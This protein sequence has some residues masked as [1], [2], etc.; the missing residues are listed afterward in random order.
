M[1]GS[2]TRSTSSTRREF[3]KRTGAAAAGAAV[4]PALLR[5]PAEALG[6]RRPNIIVIMSDEHNAGVT[7]CYGNS[8]VRTPNLDG[9][10]R[11][12]VTFEGC[13]TNSP[14]CVPSRL[15]FT[16]GKYAS[17]V[18]AWSNDC[19]LPSDDCP[20]LPRIMNAAGYESLLCGKMHYDAARRYG[21]TEV[22]RIGNKS[23]KSGKGARRKA[24]DL[25]PKPGISGRFEHFHPG[26]DSSVLNHDRK[27]TPGVLEFLEG[28][29]RDAKPFFLLAGYVA[30]HFPL[31]V[32]ERYWEPY[33]GKVPMPEIPAGHLDALPL[34]Y[35]HLRIGFNV[36][37]AP[38]D[39][40]RKGRELYYGLTEWFDDEVGKVLEALGRSEFAED[41]VVIY[42]SDHGENIGEHG[43]WWKNCM[44]EHAA[45]VPLVVSW[46]ARWTG[47]ARRTQ[48]CSLV[49]VVKTIAELGGASVPDDWDGDSMLPWL[50]DDGF[51]WKDTALSEYYAHN[52][53]SG[54]AMLRRGSMKYVYHT[55]A[56]DRRPPERE[57][58]DL[59]ADPG[60]FTNLAGVAGHE[61]IV[62]EMHAA[63]VGEIGEEPDLTEQRCRADYA[64]GYGR[65][66]NRDDKKGSKK[67]KRQ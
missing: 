57:L 55:P 53:A 50:D 59:D 12:G 32:P 38:R 36:E 33:R 6:P 62:T 8:V 65:A 5:R 40:V 24:D 26:D 29:A 4:A 2:S 15:S 63:L 25:Q 51:A 44:Y 42:T 13:Y 67:N 3:L 37:D 49:D 60:E 47:G 9:L 31:I 39:I 19:W 61:R 28:R 52:I 35:K 46:P 18:G 11:R 34:N 21:F 20:S 66:R 56:D 23:R 27:V 41:T 48:A 30:P 1:A 54:Y 16:A 7:G 43:L 45:R 17:R 14:L 10:A 58:Y 22:E 64:R